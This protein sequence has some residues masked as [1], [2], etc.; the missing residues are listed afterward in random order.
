[1]GE[2]SDFNYHY[3]HG[4]PTI[5]DIIKEKVLE[6]NPALAQNLHELRKQIVKRIHE[7]IVIDSTYFLG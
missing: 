1:M 3:I 6:E 4:G 2:K 7:E 5:E